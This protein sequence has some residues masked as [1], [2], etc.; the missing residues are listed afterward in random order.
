MHISTYILGFIG[1]IIVS[2]SVKNMG[3]YGFLWPA[4]SHILVQRKFYQFV[5]IFTCDIRAFS[6]SLLRAIIP[7]NHLPF[8]KIFSNFVYFCPCFQTF[9]AFLT[10]FA[11]FLKNCTHT[12]TFLNRPWVFILKS[13]CWQIYTSSHYFKYCVADVANNEFLLKLF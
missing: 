2:N 4:F 8:F 11:L 3:E 12:L 5:A 7:H 10:F 1:P 9:C 6:N 13:Q